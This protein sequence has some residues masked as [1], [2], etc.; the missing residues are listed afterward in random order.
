VNEKRENH[1]IGMPLLILV[2]PAL[3]GKLFLEVLST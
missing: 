2:L 1:R 3:S